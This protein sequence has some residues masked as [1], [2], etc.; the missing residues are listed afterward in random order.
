MFSLHSKHTIPDVID[1]VESGSASEIRQKSL[2]KARRRLTARFPEMV[3]RHPIKIRK[4]LIPANLTSEIPNIT[5][6]HPE[7]V[8][9]KGLF[10]TVF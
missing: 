7:N 8:A 3:S 9:E 2:L 1:P 4:T 6:A 10:L 5:M